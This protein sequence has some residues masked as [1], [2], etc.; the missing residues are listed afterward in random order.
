MHCLCSIAFD[1][2]KKLRAASGPVYPFENFTH[3]LP[4]DK[5]S[6]ESRASSVVNSGFNMVIVWSAAL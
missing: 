5:N 6:S 3:C 4:T 2:F 1:P